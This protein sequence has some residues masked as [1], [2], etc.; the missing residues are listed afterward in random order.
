[1]SNEASFPL[2]GAQHLGEPL[3]DTPAADGRH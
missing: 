2:T 1:M 3:A